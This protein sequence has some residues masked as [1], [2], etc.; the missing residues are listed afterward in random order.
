MCNVDTMKNKAINLS[1]LT[2]N[3]TYNSSPSP[4][5]TDEAA[6]LLVP[7]EEAFLFFFDGSSITKAAAETES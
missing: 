5:R 2:A 6:R 1:N 3:S 4:N 7:A